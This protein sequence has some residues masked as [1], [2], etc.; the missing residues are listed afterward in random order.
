[1]RFNRFSRLPRMIVYKIPHSRYTTAGQKWWESEREM[2]MQM[3]VSFFQDIFVC[4]D[5]SEGGAFCF[6]EDREAEPITALSAVLGGLTRF[7]LPV[8]NLRDAAI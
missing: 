6:I 4:E 5:N 8:A 3:P 7:K 2:Q 1:M